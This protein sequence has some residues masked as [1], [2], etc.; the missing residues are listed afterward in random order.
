MAYNSQDTTDTVAGYGWSLQA[1]S[2]M[3]LGTP[4]DFHPNPNPTTIKLTD[5]DGT[6]HTFTWDPAANEWKSPAGVHLFAQR[7]VVCGQQTEESRAWSLTRPDRT[8]FFYDCDG[9]LSSIEDNNGN[10]MT[11]TY[12]VRRS[13]NKPTKFLRYLTDA[14]GRQTLTIDYWAKGDTYDYIDDTTWTKVTGQANLT[15]PKIIDHVRSITDISGRKLTFTYTVKG[16]LGELV[17]GA[18]SAQPKVFGFQYDMTQGNKNVKLVKVTDPRGHATNLAY[19]SNPADDP[20][21]KWNTKTYTDRLGNPTSYAYTDPD[22]TAGSTIQTVVTDAENHATTYL[23]DGFGRPTQTTNAKNQVTKLGWDAENNVNRLEEANGAVSTWDYDPKTG[24]PTVIKDAEAVK[25]GWPGTTLA[26]Q[27]AL[28]GHLAD[29]ITKQSPEGRRWTFGYDTEGDLTSVTDPIGNTTPTVGDYTTT[30]TYDTYGQ[31]LTA[32]DA[33]G[34]TTTNCALDANGNITTCDFDPSGFPRTMTNAL[35]QS[36]KLVFDERGNIVKFTDALGKEATQTFDTFGRL[37]VNTV[38]KSAGVL[39]TTPAPTYD[40]NDNMT[41]H[42]TANGAVTTAVY[43]DADQLSYTLD[44]VDVSGD[45]ERKTSYTYDKVGNVLTTTE[46]KGNLTSAAGDYTTTNTYDEINQL[47]A[48]TNA[49]NQKLSYVYDNV[50]NLETLIDPRKNATADPNDYTRKFGHDAAHRMTTVT[51]ALG[52][53]TTTGYD[54]DGLAVTVTDPLGCTTYTTRDGRGRPVETKVPHVDS[55]GVQYRITRAEYDQAGNQTK[56]ISP[57]G[58]ATTDDPDDFTVVTVYDEL[59]RKKETRTAYDRDDAR[60]TTPD[61]TFYSYDAVGHLVKLSAPPSAGQTVRNDT[62]YSYF[63]NGWIKT[64]TDPWDIVTSYDYDQLGKQ[65][66][67]TV[68]SAGGSSSRTTTSQYYPDGKLKAKADDGVPV[69]K[70]VVLVDNSDSQNVTVTGTWTSSS[71]G[72]GLYGYDYQTHAAGTGTNSFSWRTNVPQA[73]NYEVFVRYPQVSGAATDAKITIEHAAGSTTKTVNQSLNADT[74]VSLGTYAFDEGASKKITLTDQATGT[75]VADAVKLVR[76]NTGETDTEKHDYTYRY[77]PNGNLTTITDASP[78]ATVDGY[79]VT[80]T[81]LNQIESVVEKLGA[82][83]KNTTSYTYN[84]NGAPVTLGHDK[85]YNTYEFDVRDLLAKVTNGT[86]ATDLNPK[87]T[88]FTYTDRGERQHEVKGNGNTVDYTYFLDGLVKSQTEKKS[89]GTLVSDDSL[90]YDLNG[91]RTHDVSK[92]MNADN[93]GAYLNTTT[94]YTYDPRDRI[95]S[96]VTTGDGA[97]SETYVHDANNNVISQT[98]KGKTA[99][100]VYNRNRLVTTTTSGV[101]MAYN[102]DPFGRLDTITAAGTVIE[103]NVYDGFDRTVE[104]RKTTGGATSTTRYVYDPL[105]RTSAKTT[106]AG[107]AQAKTTTFSYMGLTSEI[108]DETTAGQVA[109]SYQYSPWGERLS[110]TKTN[111]TGGKED[112]YYG[113]NLHSD[114]DEMTDNTGDTKATYGYNAYGTNDDSRFTGIDK[115]DVQNPTKEPYNVY[116]FNAKRW[117]QNRETYD[118]GFRDYSPGSNQFLTRDMYNGALDDLNLASDPWTGNRYAFGAGNPISNVEI[119][120]HD[121][122]PPTCEPTL[123]PEYCHDPGSN[124]LGPYD[125]GVEWLWGYTM[126]DPL[127]SCEV[128]YAKCDDT[129]K[130]LYFRE[131]DVFTQGLATLPRVQDARLDIEKQLAFNKEHPDQAKYTGTTHLHYVD[132]SGGQRAWTAIKNLFSVCTGGLLGMPIEQGFT[133]SFDLEW[134][135]LGE[136]ENGNAVI[137]FHLTNASTWASGVPDPTKVFRYPS[138]NEENQSAGDGHD[139]AP[140]E[141]WLQQSVRWRETFVDDKAPVVDEGPSWGTADNCCVPGL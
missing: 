88:T 40:A 14:T 99:N 53:S 125:L 59:N 131:G 106:D 141:Y 121:V 34:N 132:E 128:A 51:D 114:V 4:L 69:G 15:N 24:Y 80:Y 127:R 103:R 91:S 5:G 63:D 70:Q 54:R 94:D 20:K 90:D 112:G 33:N 82:T 17:D 6:T 78:G 77:D 113:Y 28:N 85:T 26:Y 52:K 110:Q 10:V 22:G 120:G 111:D 92:K 45:P 139:A 89:D 11:F 9:Y 97:G 71:T 126:N 3:R 50:G 13:Q 27:T 73:G 86:S 117:D 56:I 46:P 55:G 129:H 119:D 66:L 93:H 43:D 101:T 18:G 84:E 60:Y 67:R 130:T 95:V 48:V 105:D 100:L 102:Y 36:T 74:W 134:E 83:V 76:D 25:N 65:T 58:V 30:Y 118:M 96:S 47:V 75:V 38:P 107:T 136:D 41:A 62:I 133:G 21:F 37:L 81:G 23:M 16:L 61:S 137:E 12:E 138:E 116:R 49:N 44:P 79:S 31:L 32:K 39:I 42:A 72:T 104:N 7:L 140:G 29:L 124:N 2:L 108:L 1:S 122:Q 98:V 123:T 68:T 35:N 109:K 8:Q 19:Y 87:I 64:S 57:R 135:I 115:P